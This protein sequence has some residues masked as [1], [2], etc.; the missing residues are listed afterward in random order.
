MEEE[1]YKRAVEIKGKIYSLQ[2]NL[3]DLKGGYWDKTRIELKTG[4]SDMGRDLTRST[5][6]DEEIGYKIHDFINETIS[7][8][9]AELE[10]EF[11]A[12]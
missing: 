6:F 10:K 2:K 12:L 9:I 4:Y 8:K 3:E 7:N 1:I 11:K 5:V